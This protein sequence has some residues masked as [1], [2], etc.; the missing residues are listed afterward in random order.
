MVAMTT[1]TTEAAFLHSDL[2]CFSESLLQ[3]TTS[4][5]AITTCTCTRKPYDIYYKSIIRGAADFRG[6]ICIAAA[7]VVVVAVSVIDRD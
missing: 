1:T 2:P 3:Q 5:E 6:T 7:V 4:I